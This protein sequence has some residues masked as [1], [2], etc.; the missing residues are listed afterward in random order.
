MLVPTTVRF[1]AIQGLTIH[2]VAITILFVHLLMRKSIRQTGISIHLPAVLIPLLSF[3]IYSICISYFHSELTTMGCFYS[4]WISLFLF[5]ILVFSNNSLEATILIRRILYIALFIAIYSFIEFILKKNLIYSS[6]AEYA[7]SSNYIR[8]YRSYGTTNHSLTLANMLIMVLPLVK[9]A[10]FRLLI[11]KPEFLILNIALTIAI[12][13]TCSRAASLLTVGYFLFTYLSFWAAGVVFPSII[14]C[15]VLLLKYLSTNFLTQ[16]L[17]GRFLTETNSTAV[18]VNNF[19]NFVLMLPENVFG[20]GL[21]TSAIQYQTRFAT[22]EILENPWAA[23][24]LDVGIVGLVLLITSM[25]FIIRKIGHKLPVLPL[26]VLMLAM[27][28]AYNSFSAYSNLIMFY[29]ILLLVFRALTP[30]T[31]PRT[32]LNKD[33]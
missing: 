7:S 14:F 26:T 28:T 13:L 29:M 27:T 17:V 3:I 20:N 11:S 12:F 31:E 1:T 32:M 4:I 21:G 9:F 15:N 23:T 18:R 19:Q 33:K 24:V 6:L 10:R 30:T 2:S 16:N 22:T 5:L 25:V 8:T